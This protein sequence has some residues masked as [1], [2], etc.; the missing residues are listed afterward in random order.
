MARRLIP[1]TAKPNRQTNGTRHG[2]CH[3]GKPQERA[4]RCVAIR[5]GRS[6]MAGLNRCRLLRL[7]GSGVFI[8]TSVLD[9]FDL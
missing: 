1:S 5:G 8:A 7:G 2:K 3:A 4:L 6:Q 9:V